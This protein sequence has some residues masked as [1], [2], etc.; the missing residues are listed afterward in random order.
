MDGLTGD[1]EQREVPEG[2]DEADSEAGECST[3]T[4]LEWVQQV[5]PPAELL[6]NGPPRKKMKTNAM[7]RTIGVSAH[8][9]DGTVPVV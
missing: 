6:L 9:N 7:G 8:G 3:E 5:A 1:V 4:V 2:P